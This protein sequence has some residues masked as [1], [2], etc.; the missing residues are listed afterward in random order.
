MNKLIK[1]ILIL[2]YCMCAASGGSY[3]LDRMDNDKGRITKML[4]KG[5]QD[6]LNSN[7]LLVGETFFTNRTEFEFMSD[8][9][10]R[11][12]D[13]LEP[14]FKAFGTP[15]VIDISIVS[16]GGR[17]SWYL[18][19]D[20]RFGKRLKEAHVRCTVG[21]AGSMAFTFLINFCDERLFSHD[22]IVMQHQVYASFFGM[23]IYTK[24]TV[25]LSKYF[26][27]IEAMSLGISRKK[28]YEVSRNNGDKFFNRSEEYK[29]NLRTN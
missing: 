26:S 17:V 4:S 22:T 15:K 7:V 1:G 20:K 28:W 11:Y 6:K 3:I 16:G 21:F 25:E 14:R 8:N 19:L 23:A 29:F 5:T 10:E 24:D 9:I 12:L 13:S 2:I 27:N 18:E